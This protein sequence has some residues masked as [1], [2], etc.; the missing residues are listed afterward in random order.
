PSDRVHSVVFSPDGHILAT[1]D[2]DGT[3]R[4]W[5]V[6]TPRHPSPL[7]TLT[8]HTKAV[9]SVAFSPDGHTLATGSEDNT[10]RLWETDVDIVGKQICAIAWPVITKTEWDQYL[11][12]LPYR[13][14][15]P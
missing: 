10:A 15:C 6:S 11:P 14:P 12:D 5:D 2:A 9:Y 13:P 8:G 4:L 7:E 1:A 3:A